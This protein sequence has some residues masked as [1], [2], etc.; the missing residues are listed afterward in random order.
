MDAQRIQA[1]EALVSNLSGRLAKLEAKQPN[2][3]PASP[4]WNWIKPVVIAAGTNDVTERAVDLKDFVGKNAR[5]ALVQ[6][7]VMYDGGG[8]ATEFRFELF[9]LV[10]AASTTT[11]FMVHEADD[12]VGGCDTRPIPLSGLGFSYYSTVTPSV[13]GNFNFILTLQA[14]R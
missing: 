10:P 8:V 11:R 6:C 12:Q 4:F 14:W 1:L 2:A 9:V 7:D 3:P 5:E 13:T